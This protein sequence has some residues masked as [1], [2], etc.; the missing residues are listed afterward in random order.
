MYTSAE[1]V[2]N[3]CSRAAKRWARSTWKSGH[4]QPLTL[5]SENHSIPMQ[6]RDALS[7]DHTEMQLNVA[8]TNKGH[9]NCN[10]PC[11][12]FQGVKEVISS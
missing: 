6:N 9:L 8:V 11:F 4:Q 7:L 5:F 10:K 12:K 3:S 1:R 2:R